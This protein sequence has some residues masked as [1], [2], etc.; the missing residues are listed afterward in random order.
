M[1]AS[2]L[3]K[4]NMKIDKR[5]AR[6]RLVTGSRVFHALVYQLIEDL[7]GYEGGAGRSGLRG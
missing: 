6:P 2:H 4:E 3:C 5:Q 1:T 7:P